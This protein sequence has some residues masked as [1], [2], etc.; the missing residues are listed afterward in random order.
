MNID[1]GVR[2]FAGNMLDFIPNTQKPEPYVEIT[3]IYEA[4]G[5]LIEI[6]EVPKVK[7]I[8]AG[9]F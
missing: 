3:V 4:R 6:S 2:D 5:E 7:A 8:A 9:E 1:S